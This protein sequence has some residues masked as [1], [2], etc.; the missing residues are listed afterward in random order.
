MH[1]ESGAFHIGGNLS[2]IDILIVLFHKL[3][4][5]NDQFILSKRHP[6]GLLYIALWSIGILKDSDLVTF[7]QDDK[8][9]SQTYLR[10]KM[11]DR[12]K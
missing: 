12:F 10:K 2:C 3:I 1:F 5:S 9:G 11:W 6:A 4:S 7:H 8:S